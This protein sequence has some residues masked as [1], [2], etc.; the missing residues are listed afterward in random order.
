[1]SSKILVV[2]DDEAIRTTLSEVLTFMGYG[3]IAAENGQE[4][5]EVLRRSPRPGLM[6]LDL[7][8]PV[9][10]GWEVLEIVENDADLRGVPI[11]VLSAMA[12]PLAPLG[13]PGGVKQCFGKPVNLEALLGAITALLPPVAPISR[14]EQEA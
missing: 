14:P 9:L 5:L 8:M 12:A 10:S 13:T 4:A 2:D 7:M 6:L 3:C 11:L 1:M